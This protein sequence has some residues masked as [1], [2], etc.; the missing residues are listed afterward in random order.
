MYEVRDWLLANCNAEK[1]IQHKF[2]YTDDTMS[3]SR[4]RDNHS[5][6]SEQEGNAWDDSGRWYSKGWCMQDQIQ[7]Q[8]CTSL[9]CL[10]L[11]AWLLWSLN[12]SILAPTQLYIMHHNIATSSGRLNFGHKCY[13]IIHDLYIIRCID[14]HPFFF[15]LLCAEGTR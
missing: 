7:V 15:S 12:P 1:V 13:K 10:I 14:M 2:K 4:D 11:L 5:D 9:H 3:I 6:S 8:C